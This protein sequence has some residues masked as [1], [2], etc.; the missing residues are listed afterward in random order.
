MK[1]IIFV[2]LFSLSLNAYNIPHLK[3]IEKNKV[4]S[5][6][7]KDRS[8]LVKNTFSYIVEYKTIN[9]TNINLFLTEKVVPSGKI[10]ISKENYSKPKN[11]L[12]KSDENKLKILSSFFVT[13]VIYA[14]LNITKPS[15]N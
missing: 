3:L 15:V 8:M 5:L 9:A 11:L 4:E 2:L 1:V 6:I 14:V 7:F 10:I 12:R 13:N